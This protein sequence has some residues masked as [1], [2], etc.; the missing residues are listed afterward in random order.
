[1]IRSNISMFSTT[2]ET[3]T[4]LERS[5]SLDRKFADRL[6]SSTGL[7][8]I[9]DACL[10]TTGPQPGAEALLGFATAPIAMVL[11]STGVLLTL[12]M[13]GFLAIFGR[14]RASVAVLTSDGNLTSFA[15]K[16]F[17]RRM[18]TEVGETGPLVRNSFRVTRESVGAVR[19]NWR[20]EQYWAVG[21]HADAARRLAQ[22]AAN[23][24]LTTTNEVP[25]SDWPSERDLG[26]D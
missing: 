1:M 2:G 10:L 12:P 20:G 4:E 13:I 14:R 9:V 21:Q 6:E 8:N 3:V 19:V 11:G 22:A 17:A 26:F 25:G 24:S 7:S 23:S 18:T 5:R 15:L 16:R